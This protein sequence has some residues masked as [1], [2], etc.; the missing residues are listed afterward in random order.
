MGV[1]LQNRTYVYTIHAGNYVRSKILNL[2]RQVIRHSA[3]Y[4]LQTH[5]F[6]IAD[7]M[8]V[9]GTM[10]NILDFHVQVYR[11]ECIRFYTQTH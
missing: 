8:K 10:R 1:T 3:L 4:P 11:S 2:R 7:R 9:R 6:L 5:F